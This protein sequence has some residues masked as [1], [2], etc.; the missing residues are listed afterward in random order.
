MSKEKSRRK[1]TKEVVLSEQDKERLAAFLATQCAARAAQAQLSLSQV[2]S[3]TSA[4]DRSLNHEAWVDLP[5]FMMLD[6]VGDYVIGEQK[7]VYKSMYKHDD[8]TVW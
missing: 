5:Q 2:V 7:K 1:V 4:S 6:L 8:M 3:D